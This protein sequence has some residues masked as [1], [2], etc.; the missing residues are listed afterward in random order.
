MIVCCAFLVIAFRYIPKLLFAFFDWV[1]CLFLLFFYLVFY[2]YNI[3]TVVVA[4]FSGTTIP[5][6][7]QFFVFSARFSPYL[8]AFKHL[9]SYCASHSV[10][11][12]FSKVFF[13]YFLLFSRFLVSGHFFLTTANLFFFTFF[14]FFRARFSSGMQSIHM[15]RLP[16][17]L[18]LQKNLHDL[19]WSCGHRIPHC[20]TSRP[21]ACLP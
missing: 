5:R 11:L 9:A 19:W 10:F 12:F 18:R 7:V 21:P 15:V 4:D 17:P 16:H 13:C 20:Q 1:V 14:L 2:P 6:F 3:C 8:L